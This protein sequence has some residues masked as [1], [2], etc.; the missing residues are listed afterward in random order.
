[1]PVN[2]EQVDKAPLQPKKM[3]RST[4]GFSLAILGAF[5][6]NLEDLLDELPTLYRIDWVDFARA[7]DAFRARALQAVEV[8]HE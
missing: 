1:M 6:V 8:V 5:V 4:P 3:F 2:L 7:S